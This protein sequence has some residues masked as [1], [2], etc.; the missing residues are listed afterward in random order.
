MAALPNEC[1]ILLRSCQS[2]RCC[3]WVRHRISG[4][5]LYKSKL[6]ISSCIVWPGCYSICLRSG[7][8][9]YHLEIATA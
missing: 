7:A 4:R 9:S 6:P 2:N 3:L 8:R 5:Y 1:E